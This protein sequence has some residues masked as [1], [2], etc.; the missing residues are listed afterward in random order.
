ML[1]TTAARKEGKNRFHLSRETAHYWERDSTN[2]RGKGRK[3]LHPLGKGEAKRGSLP[4]FRNKPATSFLKKK[5]KNL[6]KEGRN[7]E[8]RAVKG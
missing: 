5:R 3:E 7:I 2:E 1:T 4:L 6:L 8:K